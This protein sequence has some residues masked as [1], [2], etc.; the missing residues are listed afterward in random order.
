M[1]KYKI[2]NASS[3]ETQDL[4][5]RMTVRRD[6]NAIACEISDICIES[7]VDF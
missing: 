3:S 6:A 7:S 5:Q 4:P 1:Q 2:T